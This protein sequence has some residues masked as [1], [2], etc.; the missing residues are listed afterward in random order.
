M[1]FDLAGDN[2]HGRMMDRMVSTSNFTI[3]SGVEAAENNAGVMRLT[4]SSV[5]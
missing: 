5:H 4:R 3:F 2:P 1:F